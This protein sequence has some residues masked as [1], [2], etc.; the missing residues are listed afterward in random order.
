MYI[1]EKIKQDEINGLMLRSGTLALTLNREDIM[2]LTGTIED[3]QNPSYIA[4]KNTLEKVQKLNKDTRFTYILGLRDEKQ[5]F[6]VDAEPINSPDF[7]PPGQIYIDVLPSDIENHKKGISYTKGPYTDQW[8]TW[9]SAF[10]PIIDDNQ[11]VIG[12]VGMDIDA[13]KFL[14]RTSIV[15]YATAS[16]LG[17]IVVCI[18]LIA[19]LLNRRVI[20]G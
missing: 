20:K 14:L 8:G 6:Q 13:E 9:F 10:A 4:I 15:T 11:R 16:I 2:Q 19:V 3:L 12:M 7:S 18:S 1:T 5:F 17:L